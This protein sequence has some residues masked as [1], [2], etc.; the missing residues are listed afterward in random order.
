MQKELA[1]TKSSTGSKG[2]YVVLKLENDSVEYIERINMGVL[3]A[4]VVENNRTRSWCGA[5]KSLGKSPEN[6]CSLVMTSINN[7]TLPL[8]PPQ[9]PS[10]HPLDPHHSLLY[11]LTDLESV[12]VRIKEV[13]F[14]S[15]I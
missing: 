1:A 12:V 5:N 2:N 9:P 4:I 15:I 13:L 8:P 6:E 14:K 10:R 7:T 11:P 3:D